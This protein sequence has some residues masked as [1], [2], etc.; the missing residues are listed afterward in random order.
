ME[1]IGKRTLTEFGPIKKRCFTNLM[2]LNLPKVQMGE[3]HGTKHLNGN[4]WLW[5]VRAIIQL[6]IRQLVYDTFIIQEK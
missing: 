5:M 3:I 2:E 1:K 6:R 4:G